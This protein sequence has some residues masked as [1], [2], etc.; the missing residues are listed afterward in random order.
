MGG[1]LKRR[2]VRGRL[3]IAALCLTTLAAASWCLGE[4]VGADAPRPPLWDLGSAGPRVAS[5]AY[6]AAAGSWGAARVCLA[7]VGLLLAGECAAHVMAAL[8]RGVRRGGSPAS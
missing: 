7:L 5:Y 3:V 6:A 4:L 2:P 1:F 8:R